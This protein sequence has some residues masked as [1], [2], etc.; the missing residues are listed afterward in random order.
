MQAAR[1]AAARSTAVVYLQVELQKGVLRVTADEHPVVS[2]SWDR[3]RNPQPPPRSHAFAQA[4]IDAEVRS[5]LTPIA[6]E[7]SAVHRYRQ[8]DAEIAA[9][10]CGDTDGD[11]GLELLL[12][13]RSKVALGRFRNGRLVLDRSALF[14]QLGPRAAVPLR[15]PLG[16][17]VM[18]KD[19]ARLWVAHSD[20]GAFVLDAELRNVQAL[21]GFPVAF[22]AAVACAKLQPEQ[23]AFDGALVR[24]EGSAADTM[25]DPRIG[26]FD[27]AQVLHLRSPAGV[28]HVVS[29]LREPG[30]RLRVRMDEAQLNIEGAGA[31]FAIGDLDL[32]G[33]PEIITSSEGTDDAVHVQTWDGTQL[34]TRLRL[35]APAGV[36]AVTV[37]PAE[38]RGAPALVAAVGAELWVVR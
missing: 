14:S 8:D 27:G 25:Y 34:R 3:V 23:S 19:P 16:A 1:N 30:G 26:P 18:L 9:L 22:G 24:C 15:E 28:E 20:H 10:A 6:L 11:G 13:S 38:D 35:A 5:L 4:P 17:A 31:Q 2:N 21:P 32:D 37:C 12:V 33:W 36:R 29:A 7:R